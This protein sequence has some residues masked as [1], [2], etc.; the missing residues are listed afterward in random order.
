MTVEALRTCKIC[1]G[2]WPESFFRTIQRR[3]VRS[4]RIA[5]ICIG[6]EQGKRDARK[7]DESGRIRQ[8]AKDTI[9]RHARKLSPTLGISPSEFGRR[10][11]W[12]ID[13]VAHDLKHAYDN[14]CPDCRHPF[15]QMPK[16]LSE[17]TVDI[18]DPGKPPDWGINTRICC[19]TCNRAKA[20][21]S[22]EQWGERRR[23]WRDYADWKPPE[24]EVRQAD[25]LDDLES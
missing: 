21:L 17:M 6:C 7:S 12:I 22:P 14:G 1:R 24:P 9:A 18:L 11:G 15:K 19:G 23:Q 3:S 13:H 10:F 2:Q 5:Y 4:T 8:K 20:V 25:L 16:G